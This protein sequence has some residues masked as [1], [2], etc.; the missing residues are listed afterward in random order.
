MDSGSGSRG[1]EVVG[2]LRLAVLDRVESVILDLHGAGIRHESVGN[3]GRLELL[4]GVVVEHEP[5]EAAVIEVEPS[6][7]G[8]RTQ[9]V[10][11]GGGHSNRAGRRCAGRRA[12]HDGQNEYGDDGRLGARIK[13]RSHEHLPP[14]LYRL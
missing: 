8:E 6:L 7:N 9:L 2:E 5:P 14:K 3:P 12:S 11:G 4:E 1:A 13:R 10:G